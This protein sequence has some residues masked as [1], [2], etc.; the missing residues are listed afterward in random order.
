M[1]D[2]A[3]ENNLERVYQGNMCQWM[4]YPGKMYQ[5]G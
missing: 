2:E 5:G 1:K 3:R 4:M